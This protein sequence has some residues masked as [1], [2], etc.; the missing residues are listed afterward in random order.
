MYFYKKI[1]YKLF[2]I[3]VSKTLAIAI[4]AMLTIPASAFAEGVSATTTSVDAAPT[5]VTTTPAQTPVKPPLPP[6]PLLRSTTTS[7]TRTL[8]L[9]MMASGT[10]PLSKEIEARMQDREQRQD[11]IGEGSTTDCTAAMQNREQRQAAARQRMEEK[12]SEIFKRVSEQMWKRMEAAIERLS[13]LSDRVDSRIQKLKEKGVD[14][15]KPEALISAARTKLTEA[16][17]AVD[18]AKQEVGGATALADTS[19]LNTKPDDAG[20]PVRESLGKARDA[21]FAAHKSLVSAVAS[22]KASSALR[23]KETPEAT[24]SQESMAL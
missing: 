9:R 22:L 2:M 20:K 5:T 1:F 8:P 17:A 13:K 10:K 18:A 11:C 19:A 21:I 4:G 24:S 16:K 23:A 15:T 6:R 7:G 12:R 3:T 14:I